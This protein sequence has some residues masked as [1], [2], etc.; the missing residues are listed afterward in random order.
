M[1]FLCSNILF[2]RRIILKRLLF[3]IFLTQKTGKFLFISVLNWIKSIQNVKSN[4]QFSEPI[5]FLNFLFSSVKF[6]Q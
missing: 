5:E 6:I 2:E 1:F 4:I 3:M